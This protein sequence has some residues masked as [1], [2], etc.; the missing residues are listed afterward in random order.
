MVLVLEP[1]P[2]SAPTPAQLQPKMPK[3][4]AA[5]WPQHCVYDHDCHRRHHLPRHVA[6]AQPP[7]DRMLTPEM[8]LVLEP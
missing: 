8:V 3:T 6:D 4:D 1:P 5:R 2:L 7:L